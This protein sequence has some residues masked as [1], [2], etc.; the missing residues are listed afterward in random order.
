[1]HSFYDQEQDKD[2]HSYQFY[3][4]QFQ[5]SQHSHKRGKR[6]KR[7]LNLKGRNKT[8]TAD[9][10]ILYTEN[11]KDATRKEKDVQQKTTKAHQ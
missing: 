11:P 10:M 3:S 7:N 9:D 5:E 1:M 8:V 4:T 6:N 2:A